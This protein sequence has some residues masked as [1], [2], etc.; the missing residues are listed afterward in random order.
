MNIEPLHDNV[1]VMPFAKE[2]VRKSGL[3]VADTSSHKKSVQGEVV[4]VGTGKRMDDG[5]IAPM[6]VKVGDKVVFAEYGA[7]DVEIDGEEYL[8]MSENKILGIIK[9]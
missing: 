3:I 5:S 8:M 1:V 7:E 2:E 9:S 4:A 6:S